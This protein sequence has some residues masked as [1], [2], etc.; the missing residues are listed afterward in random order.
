MDRRKKIIRIVKLFLLGFTILFAFRLLYGYVDGSAKGNEENEYISDFF[1]NMESL[2]RNYASVR[3]SKSESK[4]G[5]EKITTVMPSGSEQKFEKIASLKSKTANF[6]KDEKNLRDYV[7]K[8]NSLIQYE[9]NEGN[10]GNR[11][12][13]LSIGVPPENFD[14]MLVELKKTGTI[15]SIQVTKTDKTNEYRNLNAQKASLE[16][17]RAVLVE[18]QNKDGKIDEYIALSN[19]ILEIEQQLQEL[20]VSL[21]DFDTENE[22][23]TVHITI[24]EGKFIPIGFMHRV[25][26]SLE[27]TINYYCLFSLMVLFASGAAFFIV[28]VYGQIKS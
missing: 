24:V 3:Y 17:T 25:K 12:L 28:W 4:G 11:E 20:G 27:W 6:E 22:F 19:R 23:C 14:L 10:A 5:N 13:H 1:D 2:K 18:L 9:H 7:K 16:K 8:F 26:V 21:G 15:K